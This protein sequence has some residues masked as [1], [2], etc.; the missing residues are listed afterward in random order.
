[1]KR[2]VFAAQQPDSRQG[3]V[4]G[5]AAGAREAMHVVE[6]PGPI[7]ADAKSDVPSL[8]QV[9]PIGRYQHA[10]GLQ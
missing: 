7:D 1:M 3:L 5:A 2:N 10:I 8:E 4:K 6:T 9:A